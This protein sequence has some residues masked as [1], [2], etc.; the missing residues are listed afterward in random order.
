MRKTEF[1]ILVGLILS[2]ILC[3]FSSFK[4]ECEN[5]NE[6]VLRLHVIAHDDSED[7][8]SL[9]L[10]VR[11]A[12]LEYGEGIFTD[13]HNKNDAK[14]I[15][16]ENI[17]NIKA[18]CEKTLREN[19]SSHE[20]RVEVSEMFFNTRQYDSF[21]LPCGVYDALK[22]TIGEGQGKNWWCVMFPPMCL[23]ACIDREELSATL[24]ENGEAFIEKSPK[25]TVRFKIL[26]WAEKLFT[27]A[28]KY[29]E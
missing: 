11:D 24:G 23:S 29:E 18:V 8:Q 27:K 20:V 17:E 10:K 21:T 2:I 19:E 22:I 5:L 15:S 7:E 14:K 26:E 16:L 28:E 12:V 4:S 25:Y 9:K 1:S 6:K 13:I 3:S